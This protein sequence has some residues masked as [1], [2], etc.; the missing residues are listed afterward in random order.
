M[1]P[2]AGANP[3]VNEACA[4]AAGVLA[5]IRP[6]QQKKV[7]SFPEKWELAPS[8][9]LV[10]DLYQIRLWEIFSFQLIIDCLNC[11]FLGTF[12]RKKTRMVQRLLAQSIRVNPSRPVNG[13]FRL[14]LAHRDG[15]SILDLPIDVTK[16]SACRGMSIHLVS[17]QAN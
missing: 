7:Q 4:T 15:S 5:A 14:R 3:R 10:L 11:K 13:R 16:W 12:F 6:R 17:C 9:V 8:T 2:G 1:L